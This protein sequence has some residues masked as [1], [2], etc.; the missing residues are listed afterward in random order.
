VSQLKQLRDDIMARLDERP[1]IVLGDFNSLY[2]RDKTKETF[3]DFFNTSDRATISDVWVE[4]RNNGQFPEYQ[5][6]CRI[7][8][9]NQEKADAESLDK[10]FYINPTNSPYSLKA[11]TY[12][13]DTDGYKRNGKA[14]GDHYPVAVT[15][16]VKDSSRPNIINAIESDLQSE[17]A[18]EYYNISGQRVNQPAGGLYI[19]Q[20]SKGTRKRIVK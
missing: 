7:V 1:V 10:I 2:Y 12:S 20:D 4:L 11:I 15:F 5:E 19:E 17:E 8:D 18:K 13:R 14:M 6:D 16:E 9:E 3:V